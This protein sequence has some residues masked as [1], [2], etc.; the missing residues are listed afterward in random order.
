MNENIIFIEREQSILQLR[1]RKLKEEIIQKKELKIKENLRNNQK[2][3]LLNTENIESIYNMN[4]YTTFINSIQSS[5]EIKNS[6]EIF[7]WMDNIFKSKSKKDVLFNLVLFK[8]ELYKVSSNVNSIGVLDDIMEN[9]ILSKF[10]YKLV[11]LYEE[12]INQIRDE[13]STSNENEFFLFNH[14]YISVNICLIDTLYE[15]FI[16]VTGVK[17]KHESNIIDILNSN[18]YFLIDLLQKVISFLKEEMKKKEES[19]TTIFT[20]LLDDSIWLLSHLI[21]NQGSIAKVILNEDFVFLLISL[22]NQ[23]N[24]CVI[25]R[26]IYLIVMLITIPTSNLNEF[27][28]AIIQILV[29]I[30]QCVDVNLLSRLY[31]SKE[32][33]YILMLCRYY[34]KHIFYIYSSS[35]E[36]NSN[37]PLH[38]SLIN[39]YNHD[40]FLKQ[41][42]ESLFTISNFLIHKK[43]RKDSSQINVSN[44]D[45]FNVSDKNEAVEGIIL[46]EKSIDHVILS[47]D[48][49]S[50]CQLIIN[51]DLISFFKSSLSYVYNI[52]NNNEN[53]SQVEA[54]SP[55]I[56]EYISL[57]K[58]FFTS[59]NKLFN[60]EQID[61]VNLKNKFY[62]ISGLLEVILQYEKYFSNIITYKLNPQ[63]EFS[64]IRKEG[65]NVILAIL[66]CKNNIINNDS[67]LNLLNMF[68]TQNESLFI[69][70]IIFDLIDQIVNEPCQ[71]VKFVDLIRSI[72]N[73][74]V[75]YDLS[76]INFD[77]DNWKKEIFDLIVCLYN[78]DSGLIQKM[79]MLVKYYSFD[80][81]NSYL[82]QK[83][84]NCIE[85][86]YD[87]IDE[88]GLNN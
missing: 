44:E 22:I 20:S 3:L 75:D 61:N 31:D 10:L 64:Q 13:Q 62:E 24:D 56:I 57:L 76:L 36:I 30:N 32:Y 27:K 70:K 78:Q 46:L 69:T 42:F 51:F 6:D 55:S 71:L 1:K 9:M 11:S 15:I 21:V 33:K 59:I 8:R 14:I 81:K 43:L 5:T 86:I 58:S 79:E 84:K 63:P 53:N 83:I 40:S 23:G 12:I 19:N 68:I 54:Y 38:I 28:N 7:D 2:T 47:I 66:S 35:S 29:N 18:D 87:T 25:M 26:I 45:L 67:N 39:T 65:L 80:K 37:Y 85:I 88:I 50:M 77:D 73:K 48:S 4:N 72:F 74:H 34:Y 60:N 17:T 41:Y 82:N 49:V 52:L 16:F